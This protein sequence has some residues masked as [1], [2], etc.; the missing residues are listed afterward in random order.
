MRDSSAADDLFGH[1]L[2]GGDAWAKGVE[3]LGDAHG[4]ELFRQSRVAAT[5]LEGQLLGGAGEDGQ[6]PDD[7]AAAG[8]DGDEVLGQEQG[9]QH[10]DA[11]EASGEVERVR[12]GNGVAVAEPGVVLEGKAGALLQEEEG[13]SELGLA[14]AAIDHA[15]RPVAGKTEKALGA[16]TLVHAGWDVHGAVAHAGGDD[17]EVGAG[18][19]GHHNVKADG[20]GEFAFFV[21]DEHLGAS[22]V[23]LEMIVDGF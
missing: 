13:P 14:P 6:E 10:G 16:G 12:D 15:E 8:F 20:V 9:L 23:G 11:G 2:G 21:E 7:L 22:E 18:F 3:K 4:D 19:G 17:D 1:L 5:A